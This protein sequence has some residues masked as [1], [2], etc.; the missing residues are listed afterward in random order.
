MSSFDGIPFSV[1]PENTSW[2]PLPEL[3]ADGGYQ[4]QAQ[5]WLADGS[6][7][8]QLQRRVSIVTCKRA[9]GTTGVVC[10][11][12]AGFGDARLIVPETAGEQKTHRAVLTR[13]TDVQAYGRFVG[14]GYMAKLEFTILSDP[15]ETS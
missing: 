4:Y 3:D 15:L 6:R 12:D 5:V 1:V 2:F 7:R 14:K 10:Y 13:M 9:R 11:L 8:R